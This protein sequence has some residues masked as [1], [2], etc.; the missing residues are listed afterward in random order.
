[1]VSRYDDAQSADAL[2]SL[3]S[4]G[5]LLRP[6]P[7]DVMD[8]CYKVA[9]EVFAEICAANPE[10]KKVYDAMVAFRGE[11]FVWW[12]VAEYG[13]DSFMIRALRR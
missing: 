6:F 1:M 3:R 11:Q 2:Q 7:Q 5:M 12:S 8:A 10:F 4:K 13:Y 9:N